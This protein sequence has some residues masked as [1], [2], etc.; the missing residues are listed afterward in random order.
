MNNIIAVKSATHHG[1]KASTVTGNAIVAV[2]IYKMN[3]V[4]NCELPALSK[5]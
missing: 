1:S 3:A 5:R 2:H 4:F